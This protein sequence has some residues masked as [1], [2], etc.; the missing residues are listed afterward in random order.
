VKPDFVVEFVVKLT[1]VAAVSEAIEPFSKD[2][3]FALP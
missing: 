3:H 1:A 2:R